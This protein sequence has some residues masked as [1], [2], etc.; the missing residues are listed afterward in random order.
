MVAI[1]VVWTHEE[2]LS[3]VSG[4]MTCWGVCVG[5][6]R[7]G[8]LGDFQPLRRSIDGVKLTRGKFFFSFMTHRRICVISTHREFSW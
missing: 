7:G 1:L 2:V 8:L 4:K 3:D 5:D 6:S